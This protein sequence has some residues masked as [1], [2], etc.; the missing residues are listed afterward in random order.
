MGAFARIAAGFT[1]NANPAAIRANAP[2]APSTDPHMDRE[3]LA[4][5]HARFRLA[6][7]E[8]IIFSKAPYITEC[9]FTAPS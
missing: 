2:I 7:T 9:R 6:M 8:R 4:W 5:G 3:R 1:L